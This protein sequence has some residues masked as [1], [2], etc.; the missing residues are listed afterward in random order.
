MKKLFGI[1][2]LNFLL[3]INISEAKILDVGNKITIDVPKN[4]KY[5]EINYK[6]FNG[7]L[8][9]FPNLKKTMG[10]KDFKES[11][12][13]LGI[14][15]NSKF[16]ILVENQEALKLVKKLSTSKGINEI[17]KEFEALT[18][19]PLNEFLDEAF[20]TDLEKKLQE[21]PSEKKQKE[22]IKKWFEEP[23]QLKIME[24]IAADAIM[25]FL[26]KYKFHKY[27]IVMTMDKK[28]ENDVYNK[29]QTIG[30]SRC[31]F[32]F[33]CKNHKELQQFLKKELPNWLK[34]N[35]LYKGSN[36]KFKLNKT[37]IGKN[38]NNNLFLYFQFYM[39]DQL[40]Y[41]SLS[42]F[43]AST[44]NEKMILATSTCFKNCDNFTKIVHEIFEPTGMLKKD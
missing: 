44:K 12:K 15:N 4:Y 22:F 35:P 27:L 39:K 16:T 8:V 26:A 29:L 1:A 5:F 30:T 37:E 24:Q 25:S 14:G 43:F 6:K 13:L 36:Y 38:S 20:K 34:Q 28:I 17:I 23:A 32:N 2:V 3:T 10:N 21:I 40:T 31:A 7:L 41:D 9:T 42:E 18:E 19:G 11:L 33:K